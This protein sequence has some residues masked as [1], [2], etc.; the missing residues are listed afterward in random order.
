MFENF[1]L[2]MDW[3][4]EE[5]PGN[6]GLF[7][8][9]DALPAQGVPFTRSVEVQIMLTPDAKDSQGRLLY[10]GHGD[11]FPIHGATMKPDR[12]HPAQWSRCLP[13]ARTTKGKGQWNHYRVT[14]D[15][16]TLRLEVNGQE[17]SGGSAINPRKGYICLESEGTPI[18]FRNI[19]L[20]EL[21]PT[22]PALP[23][24]SC[25]QADIGFRSIFDATL[26]G[27]KGDTDFESHWTVRDW[28]LAF[29]GKGTDLWSR[30]SW[31]DFEMMVDWRWGAEHQGEMDRPVIGPDGREARN[32]DGSTQTIRVQERDSG[33]Y[34]RGNSKS[35]V[36]IWSWPC[37]S[38]EVYGYRTDA[39]MLGS[40]RAACTP[41]VNADAA[42]GQWNRFLIRMQGDVLNVWLNGRQVIDQAQLPGVPATGPIG[43]QSHG[44]PIEFANLQVRRLDAPTSPADVRASVATPPSSRAGD[45]SSAP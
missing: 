18:K 19:R 11:I 32:A 17:V 6:A 13:S 21:P 26:K 41:K 14:A 5:E 12:P 1:V 2:E 43:L 4:H 25:A 15:R 7:I 34:L 3:M 38:G 40:V 39:S 35:Q 9:S 36:N 16:G 29:D 27:W 24:D 20:T 31:G 42:T 33:I 37:G 30:D 8:W 10:T 22:S 28:V 44:S 23:P 45:A